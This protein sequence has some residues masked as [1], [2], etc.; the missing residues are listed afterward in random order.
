MN[1]AAGSTGVLLRAY[2]REFRERF[3][4]GM[5]QAFRDRYRGGGAARARRRRPCFL[6]RT[7]ADVGGNAAPLRFQHRERTPDELAIARLRR[8]LRAAHVRCATRCSRVLAVAALALG[9]GANTAIFTIVN[10]VL[11]KPLPYGD[12]DGLVM[13]W[14]TNAVEHRDRDVVAPLDFLDYRKAGAFADMQAAYSFIVGAALTTAPGTEQILATAVTPGMFEM[15]GRTPALGRTF[16]P[17]R[18]AD[19]R[20]RQPPVLAVA[21]GQRSRRR[22]AA[23]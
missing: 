5:Q 4:S 3:G 10:G 20:H 14:S 21:P 17:S 1:I 11:L 15:L 18:S 23:C 19:R 16:T 7:L 13:V 22:S 6:L 2:P 8:A 9:I 12:P